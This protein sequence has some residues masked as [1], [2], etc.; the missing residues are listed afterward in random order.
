MGWLLK[1]LS[2]WPSLRS[3]RGDNASSTV[4]A[5]AQT[6]MYS[7]KVQQPPRPTVTSNMPRTT[8][9]LHR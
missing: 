6:L 3:L 9:D 5:L 4:E 7:S 2:R 1:E 8:S